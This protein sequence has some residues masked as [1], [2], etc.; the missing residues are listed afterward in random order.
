MKRHSLLAL[1]VVTAVGALFTGCSEDS[2]STTPSVNS[3]EALPAA[4]GPVVSSR[5]EKIK[6]LSRAKLLSTW[7]SAWDSA[8]SG[9]ACQAGEMI[10][11]MLS[12]ASQPD[13]IL[14][15]VGAMEAGGLFTASYDGN[16]K[17]YKLT[18]MGGFRSGARDQGDMTIK[19]NIASTGGAISDFKM[20]MCLSS[21]KGR[22]DAQTEYVSASIS[23]GVATV[24]SVG[25]HSG[26]DGGNGNSYS[27]SQRTLATGA[28]NSAGSWTS[29]TITNTGVFSGIFSGAPSEHKQQLTLTQGVDHF[30]LNGYFNG[31]YGSILQSGALYAKVAGENLSNL[32]TTA[33]GEGSAKFLLT[34]AS[35]TFGST[36]SWNDSQEPLNSAESGTYY[37]LVNE[38]TLPEQSD[39]NIPAF[40]G[41]EV[42]NCNTTGTTV[43]IDMQQAMT[44][45]SNQMQACNAKY[46]FENNNPAGCSNANFNRK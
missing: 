7:N 30:V 25:T 3:I 12:D 2:S 21:R 20:W 46:G 4:T 13:K 19:F 37:Q 42:W 33:L 16:D 18:N 38:Q 35:S 32:T 8:K 31:N 9:P 22:P 1:A 23:N 40:V 15:Y 26:N 17:F 14:C 27:G 24:T 29:K 36:K 6:P 43:T 45:I 10:M 44:T 39:I 41:A 11:R 34:F 28:F 5:A